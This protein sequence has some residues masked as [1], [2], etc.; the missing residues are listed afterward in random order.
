VLSLRSIVEPAQPP[1]PTPARSLRL[2]AGL[3]LGL[4]FLTAPMNDLARSSLSPWLLVLVALGLVVFIVVYSLLMRPRRE[5]SPAVTLAALAG[6]AV[7]PVTLLA[8]GAPGSFSLLFV[9][10]AAAAGMRLR[11]LPALVVILL[12]AVGAGIS[13]GL[14]NESGSTIS[15][16]SLTVLAIGAM[17][18]AFN[19]QIRINRQLRAAR[20]GL[21]RLA[22]SEERVRI[23]RDV[24][25]LL[26]HSLSVIALKSELAARLVH[27]DPATAAKELADVQAVTRT[28]LAEV[29]EAV[30]GYRQLG[31]ADALAGAQSAL[32]A[33]GIEC[34]LDEPPHHLP[35]EVES[36][37]AWAV[38]EGTTNVVR[39]SSAARCAV[40]FA[41]DGAEAT[42]E[43]ADDGRAH[44]DVETDGTGLAGLAER[45]ER[46]RGRLEAEARAGGGFTLRVTVPLGA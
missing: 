22:V 20:E 46:L 44:A 16:K 6:L 27:D 21:S 17:M 2:I 28:A 19:R 25:D 13:A 1:E 34:E 5:W 41:E 43:V 26:G 39:H 8:A 30:Q 14:E 33:A 36:V 15:A 35:A 4:L 45:A 24:H 23:A 32:A 37:L 31:L 12:A 42:V 3:T 38:R 29:R 9:F 7:L 11:P 10:F 18:I 40:R